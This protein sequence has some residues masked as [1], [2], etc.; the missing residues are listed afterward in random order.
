MK[1]IKPNCWATWVFNV[2]PSFLINA[3]NRSLRNH[4]SMDPHIFQVRALHHA[5]NLNKANDIL[6]HNTS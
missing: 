5:P 2:V 1:E 3:A 4:Q 6:P